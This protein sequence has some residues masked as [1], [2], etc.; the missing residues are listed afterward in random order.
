M[1]GR[2]GYLCDNS[3]TLDQS[4]KLIT[5]K[6]LLCRSKG[7]PSL[8][9]EEG[10]EGEEG[11]EKKRE[12]A[13]SG[14]AVDCFHQKKGYHYFMLCLSNHHSKHECEVCL[15]PVNESTMARTMC[16]ERRA[17]HCQEEFTLLT[18]L[19]TRESLGQQG[20]VTVSSLCLW[21][22]LRPPAGPGT[23][24]WPIWDTENMIETDDQPLLRANQEPRPGRSEVRCTAPGQSTPMGK[25]SSG[26]DISGGTR[27]APWGS[28]EV[29]EVSDDYPHWYVSEQSFRKIRR[30][31]LGPLVGKQHN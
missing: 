31:V 4:L 8:R 14:Q 27:Q 3:L 11:K 22:S 15:Y 5:S 19:C 7:K 30:F 10:G 13:T 1:Y 25:G 6:P 26:A 23:T 21:E 20:T 16:W 18:Q 28:W 12:K 9:K 29:W 2:G 24:P 17:A